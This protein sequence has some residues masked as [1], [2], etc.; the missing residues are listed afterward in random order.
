MNKD[1]GFSGTK[2]INNL[3]FYC[4]NEIFRQI[5]INCAASDSK[6]YLLKYID[7]IHFTTS[8]ERFTKVFKEWSPD[9]YQK[10]C[11]QNIFLNSSPR[12]EID[13]S[14]LHAHM[15]KLS[16]KE[17]KIFWTDY[18]NN[19][20]ENEQLES[21]KLIY[22]P[23][24]Y[25]RE[26]L[27]L[28]EDLIKSLK[29]K[30]KLR[31]LIVKVKGYRFE[32]VPEIRHL[33]VLQLDVP[34]D[35]NILR[36]FCESNPNL[37]KLKLGSNHLYGR[38]SDIVPYCNQLE[39]LSFPM[40]LGVDAAEYAALAQLPILQE[41]ILFGE[42]QEGSLVKL[43]QGLAEKQIGAMGIY[44]KGMQEISLL[45]QVRRI[46]IPETYVSTDE[47]FALVSNPLLVSLKCCLRDVSI[48]PDLPLNGNL[49]DICLI[50]DPRIYDYE[51]DRLRV[52]LRGNR[53]SNEEA[54]AFYQSWKSKDSELE[55]KALNQ[56]YGH[57]HRLR[58]EGKYETTTLSSVISSLSFLYFIEKIVLYKNDPIS[59]EEIA[60]MAAIPTLTTIRCSFRQI[61]NMIVVKLR[62]LE[63]I[64]EAA[65][66][67]DR[68]RTEFF[69]IRLI[70]GHE[71]V[72][73]SLDFFEKAYGFNAR[74]FAPLANVRNIQRLVI[75]G[76]SIN[77]S[78]VALI[79][80][81]TSLEMHILQELEAE[82]LDP[83]ELAEMVQIRSLRIL[84]CGL[85][86]SRNIDKLAA[87]SQLET[88]ILTVHP[89]GSLRKFFKI[90][91]SKEVPM[92][93][94]LIIQ[95]TKLVSKE[96]VELAGLRSL[97]RLQLGLPKVQNWSQSVSGK[98]E[99]D[100]INY[101]QKCRLPPSSSS[102]VD[103]QIHFHTLTSGQFV[104]LTE[105]YDSLT[106][107][108]L[109]LLG[110]LP[111]LQE[112][113]IYFDYKAQAVENLLR[114]FALKSPQKLQKL[115]FSSQDF[116]LIGI[117]ED[118]QSLEC[119]FYHMK[120][121]ECI[122]LL[123]NLTELQINNPLDISLWEL[124]KELKILPNLQCLLFNDT[125]LVFF[126]LV[127]LTNLKRLKRLR[128]GLAVKTFVFMLIQLKNLEVLEITSTHY[129][130]I[131]ESNFIY[132]FLVSCPNL[133]SISLYRYYG[134]ITQAY[135]NGIINHC[136]IFRNP[137]KDPLFKLRGI[138]SDFTS[139]SQLCKYNEEF[140]E[141]VRVDNTYQHGEESD[142]D[143]DIAT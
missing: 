115:S 114:T 132:S 1:F 73:L 4:L 82:F 135:V 97:E 45:K 78:L 104:F 43:F 41:L 24:R 26:H 12:I 110:N 18:L 108:N 11:I 113:S 107:V 7:L 36:Q 93:K 20:K 13:F 72:T 137:N 129:A 98:T 99:N 138:W 61:Q 56:D 21:L 74:I 60:T 106:P 37:R 50:K 64:T 28:F 6:D 111:N 46:C 123:G 49:T 16:V 92:L 22:E 53:I 105:L 102:Y 85:F 3:N 86:C 69:E 96:I 42:H 63:S 44:Q 80:S 54:D 103:H 139:L 87:L 81:F 122:A 77:G 79:K 70:H 31:E 128:L 143:C 133:R 39:Y 19:I 27:D 65:R 125:D 8:C 30:T 83:E 2:K 51:M 142:E 48:Y 131:D 140:M 134:F 84:K 116:R 47:A 112:L 95:R 124:I 52:T 117:L 58:I 25:Y 57:V 75:K 33:E 9:L 15:Q 17:K 130:T 76:I 59:E 34:M 119:V 68:I 100:G 94:S 67:V 120:D 14:N 127:E 10:L 88:L 91:A 118:L 23:T 40:K 126:D 90:L 38:L 141:L 35:A 121:I 101:C 136:K 109:E 29:N 89:Q 55:L 62:Q 66:R 71:S 32:S 5:E